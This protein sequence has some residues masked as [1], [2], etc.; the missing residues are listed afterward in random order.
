MVSGSRGQRFAGEGP[1]ERLGHGLV[2]GGD[3]RLDALLEFGIGH[4]ISPAH[5]FARQDGEPGFELVEPGSMLGG[6]VKPDA[7]GSITQE[8]LARDHILQMP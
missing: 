4:E 6:E 7:V 5:E 2:E 1:A 8:R 3:E